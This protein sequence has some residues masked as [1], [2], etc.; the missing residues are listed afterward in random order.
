MG[1]RAGGHIW[2][3]LKHLPTWEPWAGLNSIACHL[4]E[5]TKAGTRGMP[6][7]A[8]PQYPPVSVGAGNRLHHA[9]LQTQ[10]KAREPYL[11][12]RFCRVH[13]GLPLWDC[14]TLQFIWRPGVVM[15]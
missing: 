1:G 4:L 3:R 7:L 12:G 14:G 11:G 8:R 15:G 2:I 13:V 5:E 9:R 6:Y 10:Q